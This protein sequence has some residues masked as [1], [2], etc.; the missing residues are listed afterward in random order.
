MNRLSWPFV[1]FAVLGVAAAVAAWWMHRAPTVSASAESAARESPAASKERKVLYWHDPMVPTQRFDKPGKSPFM[2]MQLVPVYADEG[3]DTGVRVSSAVSETLGIRLGTVKSAVVPDALTAVG[4]VAFDEHQV[5]LVQA[6]VTGYVTRLLVK[7]PLD[8]VRQGQPLA[9]I[10]APDW[11]QAEREYA[12]LLPDQPESS[13][14]LRAAARHRLIVLGVPEPAIVELERSGVV[15]ATTTMVAPIAGVVTDLGVREG[16][17]FMAGAQLFKINGLATVW[18]N[19][20]IPE[21][22]RYRIPL[23]A[24]VIAQATGWPG[25]AFRG[26]VTAVVPEVDPATRT[27]TA[28]ALLENP[29]ARL[30]PGMFVTI[31]LAGAPTTPQLVVPSEAVIAT[32]RRSVVITVGDSGGFAVAAVT[33]GAQ[34]DGMTVILSGLEEGQKIVLSGQFLIDSEASL[35]STIDRLA[36]PPAGS[37]P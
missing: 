12:E 1:G 24:A 3:G 15:K 37:S 27:L 19:A 31:R 5:A 8:P 28:R 23:G 18:V 14:G 25:Q 35:T 32:G 26:R 11:L 17:T 20:Q 6:R 30:S 16:S 9:E 13:A 2:E 7:A 10:T 36:T 33:T 29:G 22:Q 4:S 21:T 34:S